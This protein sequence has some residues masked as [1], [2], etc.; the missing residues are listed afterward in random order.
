MYAHTLGEGLTRGEDG[1]CLTGVG[2]GLGCLGGATAGALGDAFG[3]TA[4]TEYKFARAKVSRT[5]NRM[6][7]R[8]RRGYN[9][10]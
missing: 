8:A 9:L 1:G 5:K 7:F 10:I 2:V 3:V 6:L 4:S